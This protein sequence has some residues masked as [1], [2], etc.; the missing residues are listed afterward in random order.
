[1]KKN[2]IAQIISILL[3]VIL[4]LGIGAIFFIPN[5]YDMFKGSEILLFS[6]HHIIYRLAFYLGY[7]VG[8]SILFVLNLLFNKIYKDGAFSKT[9]YN[10]LRYIAV[11]FTFLSVVLVIKGIYLPTFWTFLVAIICLIVGL[12]F[13]VLSSVIKTA[14]NYKIESD[15]TI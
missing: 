11:S 15:Y 5:L 2:F 1:M 4:L 7:L 8:L 9:I 3:I 14:I 12:S 10:Y 6:E 13:Y